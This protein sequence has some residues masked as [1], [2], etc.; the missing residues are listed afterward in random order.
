[1]SK[2]ILL[3][4]VSL[5]ALFWLFLY[6]SFSS[7]FFVFPSRVGAEMTTYLIQCGFNWHLVWLD[8]LDSPKSVRRNTLGD[9]VWQTETL[10][11]ASETMLDRSV[12]KAEHIASMLHWL[13]KKLHFQGGRSFFDTGISLLSVK[14]ADMSGQK[15][16]AFL[17]PSEMWL[18]PGM[19]WNLTTTSSLS[20]CPCSLIQR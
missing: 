13:S 12:L 11:S 3:P 5:K 4:S 1:M 14:L 9:S 15:L 18:L 17:K 16:L 10:L 2:S 8:M 20:L 6:Y 19:G 7:F